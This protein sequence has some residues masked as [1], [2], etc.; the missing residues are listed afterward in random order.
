MLSVLATFTPFSDHNQ[1]PRNMYQCQMSKQTMGTPCHAF[2]TCSD[3]RIYRIFSPQSPVIRPSSYFQHS[4]DDY[5][6]GLNSVV[7]VISYTGYDMEDAMIINKCSIE[8]GFGHGCVYKNYKIDLTAAQRRTSDRSHLQFGTVGGVSSEVSRF[9]DP[10]GLPIIGSLLMKGMPFYAYYDIFSL[11]QVV[12]F[13]QHEEGWVEKVSLMGPTKRVFSIQAGFQNVC[14][15][16]RISR[17]VTIGDKFANR[18]GQKGICSKLWPTENMPFTETGITPDI[19]FN[20]HGFPSRMTIGMTIE[21]LAGKAACINGCKYD[22]T[23]FRFS[24]QTPAHLS[25][26]EELF[27]AGYNYF[28]TERM[29]SGLSGYEF[30]SDIFLGPIYY[31]RLRHMVSDKF[32][33]RTTGSVNPVTHQ[34]VQGRKRAGGMRFG[35]M[36]RDCLLSHGASFLLKDRLLNCSDKAYF[37]VCLQCGNLISSMYNH[38]RIYFED[39]PIYTYHLL[40]IDLDNYSSNYKYDW[41]CNV[42]GEFGYSKLVVLPF[43]FRLL[44]FEMA[45][46]RIKLSLKVN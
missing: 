17:N 43:V 28:G 26:S 12:Q 33:V 9:L 6:Q 3:N 35:E 41:L 45:S 2:D 24:S 32:Q 7:A 30:E 42:C 36:E 39:S 5:A 40:H 25:F 29:Y 46:M 37:Y 22:S 1:S 23:A 19:L 21:L 8:R 16:V 34:P 15:K 20:P 27:R 13:Y 44:I 14:I 11:K 31:Q 4:M 38:L 10:D 18:H